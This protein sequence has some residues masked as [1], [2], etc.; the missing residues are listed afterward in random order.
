MRAGK[1]AIFE[2]WSLLNQDLVQAAAHAYGERIVSESMINAIATNP[3]AADVLDAI[4]KVQREI[5]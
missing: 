3:A 5:S 4:Y 1:G 2:T